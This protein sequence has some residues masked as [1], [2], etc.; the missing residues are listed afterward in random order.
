MNNKSSSYH[1][2]DLRQKLIEQATLVIESNGVD[3]LSMRKLGEVIG[4]SR[5]ALY[6]HFDNKQNLLAAI[7]ESGFATWQAIT[8]TFLNED[9]LSEHDKLTKYVKG[10]L[11]FARQHKATYE[12]MFGNIIWQN[13][14]DTESLKNTAYDTFHQYL[15]LIKHWQDTATISSSQNS[16]RLAQVSW[17]TLHGMAKLYNDGIY[18]NDTNLE[19]LSQSI[20]QLLQT[21]N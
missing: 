18:V 5:S 19:E 17:S 21:K 13:E 15:N 14:L 3:A 12:L 4:V 10:Y 6:H 2:G 1:H 9:S 11:E 7:A 8:Q 16:L 20:V